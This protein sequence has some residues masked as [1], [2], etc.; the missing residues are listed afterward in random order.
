MAL[1]GNWVSVDARDR[2]LMAQALSSN[3]G[4]DKL[5][6]PSVTELCSGDELERARQWGLAMRLGQRLCGSVRSVL[7]STRLSI[8]RSALRLSVAKGEAA[9]VGEPVRR[10]L[11]QLAEAM[12]R[13]ASVVHR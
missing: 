8:D 6:D 7:S 4:R 3:F 10:R 5:P 9:L 2:V 1:H 11:T 13:E 12:G